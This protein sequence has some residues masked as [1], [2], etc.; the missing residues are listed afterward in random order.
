MIAG[1]SY[2]G[3]C[4]AWAYGAIDPSK[5]SRVFV[6]GPSHHAYLEGCAVTSH[7]SYATPIGDIAI[8]RTVTDALLASRQF[9]TMSVSIDADE[10]SIEMQLPYI[11]KVM[12]GRVFTLVPVL[13]GALSAAKE[14]LYA[15]LLQPYFADPANLFVISSDFCHWGKRFRYQPIDP[16]HGAIHKS[17]EALDKQVL[18]RIEST[19]LY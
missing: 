13:V 16:A 12:H 1:Y 8:D 19:E 10:H 5:V 2:S 14:A 9:E 15:S 17:I 4:A 7:A 18:D 6:L 11:A 3:P